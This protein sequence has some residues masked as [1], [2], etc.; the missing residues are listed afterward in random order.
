MTTDNSDLDG[1]EVYQ[2]YDLMEPLEPASAISMIPQGPGWWVLLALALLITVAL[3]GWHYYRRYQNRFRLYAIAEVHALPDD[4]SPLQISAILKRCLL[5]HTPRQEVAALT[6]QQWCDYLN[7]HVEEKVQFTDFYQM[8]GDN[9][10]DRKELKRCAI[11][12]LENYK[13]MP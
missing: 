7:S 8:R 12:W 11:Y 5:S 1:L 9:Q 6:G 2:L 3:L 10:W 4:Y 13:V